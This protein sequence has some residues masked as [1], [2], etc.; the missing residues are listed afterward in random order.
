MVARRIL[1]RKPKVFE[2]LDQQDGVQARGDPSE[3]G[4]TAT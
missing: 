2:H 4:Q 1:R 3:A